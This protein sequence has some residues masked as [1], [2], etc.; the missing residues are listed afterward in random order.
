M[1]LLLQHVR[2]PPVAPS[3]R[4]ELRIPGALDDLVLSCL[5]K[6]PAHRPQSAR[7]LSL[8]LAAM[9]GATDWTEERAREW[10]STHHPAS[11]VFRG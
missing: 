1:E 5:A 4:T 11:A 2:T 8:R 3:A 10:W 9:E 7:E 6:D